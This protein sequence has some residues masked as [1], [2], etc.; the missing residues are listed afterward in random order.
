MKQGSWI[1]LMNSGK[2]LSG[3]KQERLAENRWNDEF[4]GL[5]I[6]STP[7]GIYRVKDGNFRLVSPR[8]Q[9]YNYN[10]RCCH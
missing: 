8:F 6:M 10:R 2:R 3:L 1:L 4:S 7:V 5:L 9:P